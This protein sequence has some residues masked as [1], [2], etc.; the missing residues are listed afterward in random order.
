MGGRSVTALEPAKQ[1]LAVI[2][3]LSAALSVLGWDQATHLPERAFASRGHQLATLTE[4]LH[5]KRTDP[6][7]GRLLER[8]QRELS[9]ADPESDDACLVR[10]ALRD[11]ERAQCIPSAFASRLAAHQSESYAAWIRARPANDFASLVSGFERTLELS[12]ELASFRQGFSH[13]ADPLIDRADPGMT[14][15]RLRP[16]FS[17]L[18]GMLVPMLRQIAECPKPDLSV[19]RGD[20]D[21]DEQIAFGRKIIERIGYDFARGR[22]DRTHHPFMTRFSGDDVRITT[23]VRTDDL[24]EALFSTIHEAG[25][26]LYELGV[27]P[28]LD[29][30][31]LGSGVSA[32]VHESQ[33]RLWEN[34]VCRSRGFWN[35]HF[36]ELREAFP[37]LETVDPEVFYRAINRVEPTLVRTDAD[38]VTYNLHVIIRFDLELALLEGSLAVRDLPQAW[39]ERYRADLGVIPE[40]DTDGV[41]QDVHWYADVIGGQFQCYALGNVL[42]AQLFAAANRAFPEIGSETASGRFGTLRAWLGNNVHRHGRKLDVD[43]LI[44][45]ASGKPLSIDAYRDYLQA[46]FGDLYSIDRWTAPGTD[47]SAGVR[48]SAGSG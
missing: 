11:F 17:E 24:S 40:T 9:D 36:A 34:L 27:A 10:V 32:G 35:R 42:S 44:E 5:D 13:V 8:S 2:A 16:L 31:P 45:R 22:Q 37:Q 43:A 48:S 29:R 3:D 41:M 7:L 33:S 38:E 39:T 4:T 47:E 1:R 20:F 18:R 30:G 21:E 12:R 25:H 26:A 14:V 19:L 28:E 46:K 23:R 15:E 6:E